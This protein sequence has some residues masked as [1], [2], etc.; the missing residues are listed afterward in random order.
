MP[1]ARILRAVNDSREGDITAATDQLELTTGTFALADV[2]K[3]VTVLGA[4]AA[5]ADLY[6]TI[7][8]RADATHVTLADDAVT[9]VADAMV[10]LVGMDWNDTQDV[11]L[12]EGLD[13]GSPPLTK[14][15]LEQWPLDGEQVAESRRT[16]TRM[17]IPLVIK[18]QA[19]YA[20][21]TAIHEAICDIIDQDLWVLEWAPIGSDRSYLLDGIRAETLPALH[22]GQTRGPDCDLFDGY[23]TIIAERLPY[24]RGAGLYV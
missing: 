24:A 6:T 15:V 9:T 18:R 2:G 8:A 17:S 20:D 10:L 21:V 7:T 22:R 11:E 5:G 23:L 12:G 3:A 1:D 16:N 13:L 19:T 14:V 4:G